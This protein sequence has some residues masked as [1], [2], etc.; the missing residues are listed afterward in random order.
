MRTLIVTVLIAR[1]L[2]AATEP[3]VAAQSKADTRTPVAV[4]RELYKAH[5]NGKGAV[6]DGKEKAILLKYFDKKL[7]DAMWKELTSNSEEVGNLDFDPFF[8]SQ[9]I[10]ISNIQVTGPAVAK[11]KTVV[12]VS[13]SNYGQN[14]IIK[15]HMRNTEGGWRA[16]NI[17][18]DDGSD[19]LKIL[20]TPR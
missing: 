16:E 8:N 12:T 5:N 9:D 4:I 10:Q 19:L 18:Y 14:T 15:F 7:T 6:L 11:E 1:C 20:A 13:F 3:T 17:V 2:V